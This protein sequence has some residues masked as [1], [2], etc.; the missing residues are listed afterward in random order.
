MAQATA[1]KR[2]RPR[3]KPTLAEIPNPCI[4]C[5]K[6]YKRYEGN[7]FK[8]SKR[9]DIYIQNESR[10]PICSNCLQDL[11]IELEKRFRDKRMVYM[12]LCAYCDIYYCD[13]AYYDVV[14]KNNGDFGKYC[15]I[16][17]GQQQYIGKTFKDT[18]AE[19]NDRITELSTPAD[20]P[21]A[22]KMNDQDKKNLSFVISSIGYDCF[23]DESWSDDDRRFAFNTLAE[24]LTDDVL[25]DPHKVQSV[26]A[27]V[28]TYVQV[29]QIDKIL[30][31]ELRKNIVDA[32]QINK[33]SGV[34][35][36]L[37]SS[38]N[39]MAKENGISAIT[40]GKRS[41]GGNSLTKIM[42]EMNDNG[43]E[44]IKTNIILSKL[45]E[46]Y[47]EVANDNIKAIIA[48]LALTGDEYA[49]LLSQQTDLVAKQQE[50]MALLEEDKRKLRLEIKDLNEEIYKLDGRKKNNKR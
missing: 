8:S 5:G 7:F 37:L 25:E 40:S 3:K 27:M 18:L 13:K 16:I 48:E 6:Q 49:E 26:I 20:L 34:K 21:I 14:E 36:S 17:N 42:R 19:L 4:R 15:R 35:T 32:A 43:F 28:K 12:T 38:I 33:L 30:N 44:E 45:S 24:Y 39:A 1:A 22:R 2:G 47:Q 41:Q 31:M 9:S 23:D 11:Q 50:K 29:E 46:S 10:V